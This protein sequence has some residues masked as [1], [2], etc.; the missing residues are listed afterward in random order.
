M[1]DDPD[2]KKT[3][4]EVDS[5]IWEQT[6]IKNIVCAAK[7]IG[8]IALLMELADLYNVD[9]SEYIPYSALL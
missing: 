8:A 4:D 9:A 3:P 1:A 5:Y 7:T 6:D 2:M